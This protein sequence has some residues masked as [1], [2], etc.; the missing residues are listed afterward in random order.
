MSPANL[1]EKR[2]IDAVG[3][4]IFV[5]RA[6]PD[7]LLA[8]KCPTMAYDHGANY[9]RRLTAHFPGLKVVSIDA[10]DWEIRPDARFVDSGDD[11]VA[12]LMRDGRAPNTT[13][14]D[15]Q[16]AFVH[17]VPGIVFLMADTIY[18]YGTDPVGFLSLFDNYAI[19]GFNRTFS[20]QAYPG[21]DKDSARSLRIDIRNQMDDNQLYFTDWGRP[22]SFLV[23]NETL[24]IQGSPYYLPIKRASNGSASP[25]WN[26]AFPADTDDEETMLHANPVI[27]NSA[28]RQARLIQFFR[29]VKDNCKNQ[30]A[31][32]IKDLDKNKDLEEYEVPTPFEI[33][34]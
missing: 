1:L 34:Q 10:A 17:R 20:G 2:V 29:Y 19:P 8:G 27:Y 18:A 12:S 13:A 5:E 26:S 7:P 33:K 6:K 16:P 21:Y 31:D 4:V 28:F 32:F 3:G 11:A 14:V 25:I 15:L 23:D 30:W 9:G 22:F 24:K